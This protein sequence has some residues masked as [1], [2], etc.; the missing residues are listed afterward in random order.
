MVRKLELPSS[1]RLPPVRQDDLSFKLVLRVPILFN[2]HTQISETS[3]EKFS[4]ANYM[5]IAAQLILHK[6]QGDGEVIIFPKEKYT[7]FM[8]QIH[9]EEQLEEKPVHK[10]HQR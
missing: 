9:L 10:S 7:N 4:Y 5:E 6:E 8:M 3:S 2:L 1:I